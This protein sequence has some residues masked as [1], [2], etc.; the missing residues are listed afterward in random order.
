M[1]PTTP[2]SEKIN[3]DC[4]GTVAEQRDSTGKHQLSGHSE[5]P[6]GAVD[7]QGESVQEIGRYEYMDIR[8]S[9][10]MEGENRVKETPEQRTIETQE[11]DSSEE[12]QVVEPLKKQHEGEEKEERHHYTNKHT[13]LQGDLSSMFTPSPDVLT[14]GGEKVEEYEEMARFGV[15]SHGWEQTEYQ[16]LP[17]TMKAV[18]EE[19]GSSRCAGLGGYIKVCSGV[20]EPGN[21]TSFDNPDYWHSRLFLKPDA[22][23]T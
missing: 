8:R 11:T 15:A 17:V 6:I 13:P 21:S 1:E 18:S 22:V 3:E 4:E 5:S 14:A 7:D 2:I 23:R 9:D 16:N 12:S 19:M 20:G 10:S